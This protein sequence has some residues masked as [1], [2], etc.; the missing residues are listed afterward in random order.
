LLFYDFST[1]A[2]NKR[3]HMLSAWFRMAK[4]MIASKAL[5]SGTNVIISYFAKEYANWYVP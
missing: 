2:D 3:H 1:G 5:L 4:Q